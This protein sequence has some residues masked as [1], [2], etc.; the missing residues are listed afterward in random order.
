M[1]GFQLGIGDRIECDGFRATIR[2]VGELQNESSGQPISSADKHKVTWLGVE[3]DDPSRGKHDGSYK[4]VKY[5]NVRHPTSGSFLRPEK[6]KTGIS[7][8]EVFTE[9]YGN[10]MGV[11]ATKNLFVLG[12]NQ[13]TAVE[14]VGAEKVFQQQSRFERLREVCLEDSLIG[15]AGVDNEIAPHTVS[16]THLDLRHTLLS[17]WSEIARIAS[18]MSKLET[19]NVSKNRLR[20]PDDPFSLCSAFPRVKTIYLNSMGYEWDEVLRC[21]EMLPVLKELHVCFNCIERLDTLTPS[22]ENLTLLNLEGNHLSDWSSVLKL[23]GL[24]KLEMLI[25]NDT[26]LVNVAFTGE[27]G[28]PTEQFASL[29]SLSL[30]RNRIANWTSINELNR[31]K[32]LTNLTITEIPLA[33]TEGKAAMRHFII[34]RV[35]RLT[36]CNRTPVSASERRGAELDYLRLFGAEWKASGGGGCVESVATRPSE[37][38]IRANPRYQELVDCYGAVEDSEMKVET[39]ALKNKLITVKI[40]CSSIADKPVQTKKLPGTMT[41]QKLKNLIRRLYSAG[42]ASV[43]MKLTY[44]SRRVKGKE[45]ELDNDLREISYYSIEDG[46]TIN[47]CWWYE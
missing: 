19:F 32:S 3:W 17:L 44:T 13:M 40:A 10:S 23:G 36:N 24:A 30:S 5:F 38:F 25:L 29:N 12:K 26:G 35:A 47:A 43:T 37:D 41:V 45:I 7:F 11:D 18:Q 34:A 27:V 4:G 22:I 6:C 15:S 31:L 9:R 14:M 8:L 21:T 39:S 33:E 28:S 16:I 1:L 20:L 2:F 46:D 42:E